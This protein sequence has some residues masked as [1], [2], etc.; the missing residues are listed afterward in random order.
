MTVVGNLLR[1]DGVTPLRSL[2][3][4][5]NGSHVSFKVSARGSLVP[6][7]WAQFVFGHRYSIPKPI[8]LQARIDGGPWFQNITYRLP[9][10]FSGVSDSDADLVVSATYTIDLRLYRGRTSYGDD[11]ARPNGNFRLGFL[12]N[13][14]TP[15]PWDIIIECDKSHPD[16]ILTSTGLGPWGTSIFIPVVIAL[17]PRPVVPPPVLPVEVTPEPPV[18]EP[19]SITPDTQNLVFTPQNW[20]IE[21]SINLRALSDQGLKELEFVTLSTDSDYSGLDVP[22]LS[23]CIEDDIELGNNPLIDVDNLTNSL[24]SR[25]LPPL[26]AVGSRND[27]ILRFVTDVLDWEDL[28]I[29]GASG[30][31]IPTLAGE[32]TDV[33]TPSNFLFTEVQIAASVITS[34]VFGVQIGNNELHFFLKVQF[35]ADAIL[36]T[37]RITASDSNS[38]F[39]HVP[40]GGGYDFYLSKN[41][42]GNLMLGSNGS[43]SNLNVKVYN[44]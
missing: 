16:V 20:N 27:K 3:I 30:G 38:F 1:T 7:W 35:D 5:G 28:T 25:L 40:G 10:Y 12:Y 6:G 44:F 33:D 19:V 8:G 39:F 13:P 15:T 2:T 21:Q 9:K 37:T 26:P 4:P 23:L 42:A 24:I 31:L 29:S 32:D 11:L 18:P 22:P 43:Q 41:A 14:Y 34:P 36:V 17:V